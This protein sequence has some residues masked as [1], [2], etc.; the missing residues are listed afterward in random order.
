MLCYILFGT[1]KKGVS[2]YVKKNYVGGGAL[3][4]PRRALSQ[5]LYGNVIGYLLRNLGFVIKRSFT[6][7]AMTGLNIHILVRD[8]AP[9]APW[10]EGVRRTGEGFVRDQKDRMTRSQAFIRILRSYGAKAVGSIVKVLCKTN[11]LAGTVKYQPSSGTK[12]QLLPQWEEGISNYNLIKDEKHP[13]PQPSPIG[14]GVSNNLNHEGQSCVPPE[15]DCHPAF[16]SGSHKK[17]KH[18]GQSSVYKML[19]QVQQ[20]INLLKRT[21]S[22]IN[23]F[24]YSPRKRCAF[25]LAEVLITLGII[26]V[27]AAM[28]MPVVIGNATAIRH[29]TQFKKSLSV[30][31][32]ALKLYSAHNDID[33]SFDSA[34][35]GSYD[36]WAR[37]LTENINGIKKTDNHSQQIHDYYGD[38]YNVYLHVLGG[39]PYNFPDFGSYD[40]T[41]LMP[42]GTLFAYDSMR[43][44]QL[45]EGL[46][47]RDALVNANADQSQAESILYCIGFIDVN[48][49]NPPNKEVTCADGTVSGDLDEPCTLSKTKINDIF[50]VV[51]YGTT[52]MPAS[53]AANA[54]LNGN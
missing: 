45:R 5:V 36:I 46:S 37:V 21:Y 6:L 23:L 52:V 26:G 33:L 18:R 4:A 19:E 54:V 9:L 29:K 34:D 42:D 24:S 15:I 31:N 47:L 38:D 35:D 20:D 11:V 41:Y 14:E 3:L 39:G 44:C 25:T 13:S 16:V 8:I 2:C 48:G 1:K 43:E 27:V 50:P 30:L 40:S 10:G 53:N 22:L 51:Y 17:L 12:C 32:Q 7:C 49:L 28:T